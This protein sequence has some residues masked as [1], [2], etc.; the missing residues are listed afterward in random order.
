MGNCS[1]GNKTKIAFI[2]NENERRNN[3]ISS[4]F[5]IETNAQNGNA[6]LWSR[7]IFLNRRR[8]ITSAQA[9]FLCPFSSIANEKHINSW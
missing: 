8:H 7:I 6:M 1:Q 5:E 2:K 9:C 3:G 4:D